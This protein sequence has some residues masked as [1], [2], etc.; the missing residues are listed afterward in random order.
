MLK[1]FVAA[2]EGEKLWVLRLQLSYEAVRGHFLLHH[3]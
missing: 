2:E 1:E 3:V